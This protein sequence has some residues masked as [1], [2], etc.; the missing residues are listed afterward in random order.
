MSRVHRS[1]PYVM[2]LLVAMPLVAV[3][4]L[5]D[6]LEQGRTLE[7]SRTH[8][9]HELSIVRAKLEAALNA[10]LFLTSGLVAYVSN[11]PEIDDAEFQ[12]LAATLIR[13]QEGIRS[14]QLARNTVVTHLY[15]LEGNEEAQG[16]RLWELPKQ[17]TVVPRLLVSCCNRSDRSLENA[18]L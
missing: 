13:G 8:V 11:H 4:W 6:H 5:I 18:S 15:P 9:L 10:K 7:E 2:A 1:L 17:R 12:A 14:I 3:F 16:L